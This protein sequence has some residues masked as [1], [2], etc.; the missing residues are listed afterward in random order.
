MIKDHALAAATV[1]KYLAE[2][3]DHNLRRCGNDHGYLTKS[4]VNQ[5]CAV[6]GF[7][8]KFFAAESFQ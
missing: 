6:T 3:A 7:C 8:M 2:V 4:N 1:R 5:F